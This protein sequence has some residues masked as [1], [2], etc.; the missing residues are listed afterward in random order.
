[1]ASRSSAAGKGSPELGL[2]PSARSGGVERLSRRV[3]LQYPKVDG[4]ASPMFEQAPSGVRQQLRPDS[5]SL[6][7]APDVEI[8]EQG[9]H[10]GS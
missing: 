5:V 7:L 10:C 4:S 3:L 1:V 8:V 2:D 6:E 9:P